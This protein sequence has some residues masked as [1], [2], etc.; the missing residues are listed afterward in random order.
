MGFADHQI[1]HGRDAQIARPI[2]LLV[3]R[4]WAHSFPGLKEGFSPFY[5]PAG[6][7]WSVSAW[8]WVPV[9]ETATFRGSPDGKD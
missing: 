9:F 2:Q 1:T 6:G 7:G 5:L 8:E 4:K 3:P